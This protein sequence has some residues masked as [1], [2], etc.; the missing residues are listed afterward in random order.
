M[1]NDI[2]DMMCQVVERYIHFKKGVNVRINRMAVMSDQ[3]Q[4]GMLAHA[5]EI[6]N[7]NK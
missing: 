4:F 3:R 5:Y 6:A 1:T 7:G 2:I